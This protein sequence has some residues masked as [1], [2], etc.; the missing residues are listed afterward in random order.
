MTVYALRVL[1]GLPQAL[2][3]SELKSVAVRARAMYAPHLY[4]WMGPAHTKSTR[5]GLGYEGL[6][7]ELGAPLPWEEVQRKMLPVVRDTPSLLPQLTP[8]ITLT[9]MAVTGELVFQDHPCGAAELLIDSLPE[10]AAHEAAPY[11]DSTHLMDLKEVRDLLYTMQ[12]P[13]IV[14][15]LNYLIFPKYYAYFALKHLRITVYCNQC[16]GCY[17]YFYA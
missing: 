6:E 4:V 3:P 15:H 10:G 7:V 12:R 11:P 2:L 16:S 13:A 5:L 8:R 1:C 9:H 14:P 17:R